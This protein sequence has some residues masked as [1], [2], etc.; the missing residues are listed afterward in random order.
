MPAI[1]QPTPNMDRKQ[2]IGMVMLG[3]GA[4]GAVA[5]A[6]Q[7]RTGRTGRTGMTLLF[8]GATLFGFKEVVEAAVMKRV[9]DEIK[10]G[11]QVAMCVANYALTGVTGLPKTR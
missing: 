5:S 7:S 8:L 4:L 3:A 2:Q 11:E 6:Y 1:A 10:M 9:A